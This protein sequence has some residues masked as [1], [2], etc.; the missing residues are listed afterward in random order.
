MDKSL[1]AGL[2]LYVSVE[3]RS[4][5]SCQEWRQDEGMSSSLHDYMLSLRIDRDVDKS[6]STFDMVL[7]KFGI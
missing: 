6:C 1:A 2:K 4:F 3:R 7:T 5:T